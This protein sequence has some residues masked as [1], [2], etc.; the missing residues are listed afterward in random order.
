[1]EV[2]A[3]LRKY[4]REGI[5]WMAFLAK[6]QLHG[7]LCDG[8]FSPSDHDYLRQSTSTDMGLG[9]TLQSICI[10]A[11]KHYERA[12]R[13]RA[14]SSPD[15]AHTPSLVV[16]PPTLT[17]HW[18]HEI[19]TYVSNLR[20]LLYVGDVAARA[21]LRRQFGQHDVVITSY[22][23]IRNDIAHLEKMQWLYCILDE[24][25]IIKNG[26]SKLTQAVKTLR[27]HHRIILSGTP[28]QNN[29]LELWSLFDF[30]M[31]GFLGSERA[32][33]DRYGKPVQA[34][35]DAKSSS[36][37]QSAGALA[38][39]ALHKQVLPFLLRRLKED[40]L[41][42]LPPKI[43]QDYYCDLS[44]MQR[45]LYERH[46]ESSG[47]KQEVGS[48]GDAEK[49]GQH[50]FQSLQYLRQLVNHPRLVLRS[51]D[52]THAAMLKRLEATKA[53]DLSESP[54]LQALRYV[55]ALSLAMHQGSYDA[56]ADPSRLRY[57]C[58]D[59]RHKRTRRWRSGTSSRPHL[60][61]SSPDARP[62]RIRA[63]AWQHAE[64]DV[65]AH[66]RQYTA[67]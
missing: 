27:S 18:A 56:Q 39:E 58:F 59:G 23:V 10:L 46:G 16:C 40:V 50:I 63:A 43:I 65:H 9:K 8:A 49:A 28:I 60:L 17:G 42:D 57:R 21:T 25:H 34:S 64:R 11:S 53:G 36:K 41:D 4:Q 61:S 7:I 14:T 44:P 20:P 2:K 6:F 45:E 5:S 12:E 33:N 62:R 51:D 29:V 32:F 26:K 35:R 55:H 38:L 37:Q 52:P 48:E 3:E 24:G 47:M 67:D 15:S 30:L 22:D 54:K 19:R 13:Y 31:P 1:M 66:G